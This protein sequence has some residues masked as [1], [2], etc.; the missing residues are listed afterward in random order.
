MPLRLI[1]SAGYAAGADP[2]SSRSLVVSVCSPST[3]TMKSAVS[4]G[5]LGEGLM[6]AVVDLPSH[7]KAA[8]VSVRVEAGLS[9]AARPPEAVPW[10][11]SDQFATT[12][13]Y[14][15]NV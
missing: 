13:K 8:R 4:S 7:Q 1:R 3:F 9:P 12:F 2:Y 11:L 15:N 14:V 5:K 6:T 10:L